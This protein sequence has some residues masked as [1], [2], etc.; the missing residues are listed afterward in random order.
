[1]RS[2]L[3]FGVAMLCT[4]IAV[5]AF[6]GFNTTVTSVGEFAPT[7]VTVNA[8]VDDGGG[9][10]A[11]KTSANDSGTIIAS[12]SATYTETFSGA[13]RLYRVDVN[14]NTASNPTGEFGASFGT[15]VLGLVASNAFSLGTKTLTYDVLKEFELQ[16]GL[17]VLLG[18]SGN[19]GTEILD[20][21][22]GNPDEV[23]F[24]GNTVSGDVRI[25]S[26][27]TGPDSFYVMTAVPEPASLA[28]WAACG[29]GCVVA[30]RRRKRAQI[31]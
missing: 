16:L 15:K 3:R 18:G 29:L 12:Q 5:P 21:N 14:S 8:L 17:P 19:G 10:F 24:N 20:Y 28:I 26:N 7:T 9:T 25:G 23:E 4:V 6:A 27:P 1:M 2:F 30:A 13:F 22:S 31:A 11:L